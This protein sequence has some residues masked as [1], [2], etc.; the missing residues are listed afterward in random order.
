[1]KEEGK[2]RAEGMNKG[3]KNERGNPSL[4]LPSFLPSFSHVKIMFHL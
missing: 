2:G 4:F 3:R 1:M